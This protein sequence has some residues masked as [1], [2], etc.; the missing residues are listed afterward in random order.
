MRFLK[1]ILLLGGLLVSSPWLL[2]A[3]ASVDFAP[4]NQYIEINDNDL[5]DVGAS[6][7]FTIC[8]WVN[9]DSIK[10]DGQ[11]TRIIDKYSTLGWTF[12]CSDPGSSSIRMTL[13]LNDGVDSALARA[14]TTITAS[15][16]TFLCAT[17]DNTLNSTLGISLF[18]NGV[19]VSYLTRNSTNLIDSMS[20]TT[21]VYIGVLSDITGDYDGRMAYVHMYKRVLTLTE[22]NQIMIKPGSITDS[23]VGYWPLW[24]VNSPEIDLSGNG[25]TGT[26]TGATSSSDGPPIML[27]SG[28]H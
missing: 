28:G 5:F 27:S 22:I 25:N 14:S 16:W 26:V 12:D 3:G 9:I 7:S 23:L 20:N 18:K 6:E 8:M 2:L 1:M 4:P 13:F 15:T 24:G 10:S 11:Y 21:K 17:Y 19:E